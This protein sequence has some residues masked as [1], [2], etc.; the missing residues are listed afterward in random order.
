MSLN[1]VQFGKDVIDQFGRYLQTTFP[2]AD[3][4]LARQVHDK[5]RHTVGGE[6]LL[7][8]GPYVYLNRPFRPGPAVDD[9]IRGGVLHPA[10]AGIFPFPALHWHQG[11]TIEAVQAG[12]HV[13]LST[14]TGSGKTEAFMLPIVDHCLRL[15]DHRAGAGVVAVLVYP[16]NALVNDQLD[17]LR[18]T[19]AGTGI[20]FGRYT[21]ESPDTIDPNV[22]QQAAPVAYTT[23]QRE[24]YKSG[25][26]AFGS[27]E[28]PYPFEEALDKESIRARH[29]RLL[30]TNYSQLEYLLLRDRDLDIF[31][32]APLRFLVFDEVHT[33]TG[34]LGS[35]VACLIRRLRDVV[36]KRSD[37]VIM[38]G[39]SATVSDVPDEG[40]NVIDAEAATR[41]F[42]HRLFGVPENSLTVIREA[43]RELEIRPQDTYL[44]PLPPDMPSLLEAILDAARELQLQTDIE[45][46]DV[47]LEL[48]AYTAEMCG[49]PMMQLPAGSGME[50]LAALLTTNRCVYR[51]GEL[52]VEP[53]TWEDVM[54]RW[55]ILS[56]ERES[57]ADDDLVAEMLAYLTVGALTIVDGDPLL[58]PKLHYFIQGLQGMGIVFHPD[59]DPEIRFDDRDNALPLLLCRSCGQHYTRVIG[60]EWSASND[61]HFGYRQ[62]RIPT[63]F[64][65]PE[66]NDGTVWLYLTDQFH[67]REEQDVE[68]WT[69]VYLCP[70]CN[71]LH[72]KH[73]PQCLNPHCRLKSK[74]VSLLMAEGTPNRCAACSGPNTE[75]TRLISYTRSAGVADVTIL[76]QSMLTMMSEPKLRKVLI[77]ADSR[78]EAAF[79]AGW[80]QRRAKRFRLRH[81]AYQIASEHT[82]PWNWFSFANEVI[83][84]AQAAGIL[85][86]ADFGNR[87]Q[88]AEIRW[89]MI[90]EFALAVQRRSNLEQLGLIGIV[91]GG[92]T[93][94]PDDQ[95]FIEWAVR[96]GTTPEGIRDCVLTLLDTF[97]RRGMLS[98]E[99]LA[100]W[101]SAQDTE[102]YSDLVTVPDFYRPQALTLQPNKSQF[103]KSLLG[104]NGQSAAQ[105]IA[106]KA[107][108]RKG[109]IREDFLTAVWHW[110]IAN[111]YL[112]PVQFKRRRAGNIEPIP[113]LP[114]EVYQI[115]VN[116]I[117]LVVTH[118]RFVCTHC[119]RAQQV[120]LPSGKCPEYRCGGQMEANGRDEEHFDVVLYT[121]H[122]YVPLNAREHSAQVSQK[123]RLEA[124]HSFKSEAGSV[125]VIVA[126]PTLEM[127]VDIGQLEMVM[128]RNVPPTPA[129][130]AQRSG[131]A[132]RRHR[133]AAVFSYAGG[134]QH[135]RYFF[136]SPPEMIAG[137]I[138]VPAFSMQNAPLIRKHVHSA[139]LTTLRDLLNES[140]KASLEK[141][142]PLYIRDYL[143]ELH[144]DG[145]RWRPRYH[146]SPPD[147][148]EFGGL[149]QKHRSQILTRI[150]PIFR[151]DWPEGDA[152]AVEQGTLL[153]YIDEM[154]TQLQRHIYMLFNQVRVYR[155]GLAELR[156]IEHRN[157]GLTRDERY[158]RKRLEHAVDNFMQ[159]DINNYALSWL[160][161]D[162]FFPGY[163][164]SRGSVQASSIDPLL[165]LSRPSTIALRELTPANRV[166]ADG[167]VFAIRRMNFGKL[168]ASDPQFSSDMLRQVMDY[169][170]VLKR[171][172]SKNQNEMVADDSQALTVISYE[173]T[174]V[175]MDHEQ[176]ID[177]R[178]E[179]RLRIAF[180]IVGMLLD[181]HSG[182]QY[183]RIGDKEYLFLRQE[184]LRLVNLGPLRLGPTGNKGFPL[185]PA[186]G[187]TRSPWST[188]VEI[189]HFVSAHQEK[190][191]TTPLFYA[192]HVDIQSD[193]LR[194]GPFASEADAVN[195]YEGVLVGARLILDMGDSELSGFVD[196]DENGA[197]WAVLYD[198][199]P[200]GTGFLDLILEYWQIICT[201]GIEALQSC[202][203]ETACYQCLQHFRNQQHHGLLNRHEAME[204]LSGM[205]SSPYKEHTIPLRIQPEPGQHQ[206]EKTESP[207]E[208][209]FKRLLDERGFSAPTEQHRV[210]LDPQSYTVA[211]FAWVEERILVFIDGT[212]L[213]LHGGSEQRRK[214]RIKR[215][216]AEM[217][218]WKIVEITAQE[219]SDQQSLAYKL[220]DIGIY[221]GH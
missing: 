49:V 218:G 78:Q 106:E 121:K 220:D 146:D 197:A 154:A 137:A 74:M 57:A 193:V 36:R 90:E 40:E 56:E 34:A 51:L 123:R 62:V 66:E 27:T 44:P 43:Y 47:P 204:L 194:F 119:H 142:F 9:L 216:K 170:P 12:Q 19:L 177:D 6:S 185:C 209:K 96:M 184:I 45:E 132:G 65:E 163:T 59:A 53:R 23:Q 30:L 175:E 41:R 181:R 206:S 165:E 14:G 17:R 58:R 32:G 183:G 93:G 75:K 110:L 162:G 153:A 147:F 71:T 208:D 100:R 11:Q 148:A 80:M 8:R 174:D 37:E 128:M 22:H 108:S 112:I 35:E 38:I 1:P 72:E 144:R 55:R 189:E 54:P 161:S 157:E 133:I 86:R 217:L 169:N 25:A 186:C 15:R 150:M 77:F 187:E 116:R 48:V 138:R 212:S 219:L 188:P 76:A 215:R 141:T 13:I 33:Y 173:L 155:N 117:G 2:V 46:G 92:L 172:S 179:T 182:G 20:T 5:L 180:E 68:G 67:T 120:S 107:F 103:L 200:G 87:E 201:R 21:G 124:E 31:R 156:Q 160:A 114:E 10:T 50:R 166:Y 83:A 191:A 18:M 3:E 42:A 95:F 158:L 84:R 16:M 89:F 63:R 145:D 205:H 101:W 190:C 70:H 115:N 140:E 105:L 126:T 213:H 85:K 60:Y 159:E 99:L 79:Q 64:E 102:V 69:R 136:S 94:S 24:L 113:D 196:M 98:D 7:Y 207:A 122:E 164:L 131:R 81:I 139:T 176:D 210:D 26:A 109:S 152:E 211:D 104:S 214:D 29:P 195:A 129:N 91:Y 130:Y 28:L 118:E 82:E 178:R 202:T 199:L 125:N 149:I 135:D 143:A 168:K 88:Q 127:G 198:T 111:E 167:T 192:L 73:E 52:F 4:R 61:S 39:T 171:L 97:R 151:S 203:C 221:L 134:G